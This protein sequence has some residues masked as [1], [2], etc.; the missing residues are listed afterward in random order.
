MRPVLRLLAVTLVLGLLGAG[1]AQAVI[2]DAPQFSVSPFTK[3]QKGAGTAVSATIFWLPPVFLSP[4]ASSDKQTVT[5]TQVPGGSPQTF[6]AAANATSL[7]PLFFS[8]GRDYSITV[9]ACQT[10]TC[11]LGSVNT[12]ELTR[13]TRIDATPPSGTVQIN[14][15]A[16]ATNNRNVTLNLQAAD[17]L[18]E[19][20]PDTSSGVTQSATDIDGDGTFPCQFLVPVGVTP[21]TSGCAGNFNPATPATLTAGDG[22]KT[23]GVVFG[24]GARV[25]TSP[26][27]PL[28]F[29]ATLLG[30]PILGNASAPATDTILLDTVKP[31]A[32]LT[33]DRFTVDRGG[34]VSFDATTSID[35]N[36]A[37]ASGVDPATATWQFKDGTPQA[38]GNKV[39]HV[40]NQAG[41]F[42][43]D[44]R[45]RDRAGNLS[46]IRQF[47]VTVNPVAGGPAAAGRI[48]GITGTAAFN[49][50]RLRVSA[51]YVRSRLKGSVILSGSSTRAGA[52]RAE[53][54]R[55]ARGRVLGRVVTKSLKVGAF[56]RTLKLPATLLPGTYR[57]S[58]VGPGGT[59]RTTLKLAAPREGVIRSGRISL[60]GARASVLFRLAAQPV[61]ALRGRLTV[62]WSQGSR[63]L[64]TVPVRSG[65]SIRAALPGG[66]GIG[67]GRLR[68]ELRA[69]GTV[70]GSA[71]TVLR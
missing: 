11:V 61:K 31:I 40:F 70:V 32:L 6:S 19:G 38:T 50:D 2:Q 63:R 23:V 71:A 26:C 24:D 41:T 16:L 56:T 21:D 69:G 46:D 33:Q 68:A 48:S 7:G 3:A 44:L 8:D 4:G 15:G 28:I 43:G 27:P 42:V 60:S 10:A 35:Q 49:L 52:L 59:L 65:G 36:P 39:S 25:N 37:A 58:F 51:R 29:C 13:T 57:L 34:R 55:T 12:A 47:A 9:A 66:A 20:I 14:G 1:S 5:V 17:P 22:T 54:R 45:I 18:I 67:A 53:L 62:S 64:G 30:S